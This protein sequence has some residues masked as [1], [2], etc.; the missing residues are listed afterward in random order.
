MSKAVLLFSGQAA[1]KVGMGKDLIEAY[2]S[3]KALFEKAD[4]VLNRSLTDV[5][6]NGPA[7]DLTRTSNCQPALLLHGL[8]LLEIL[9]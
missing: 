8:A 1:Q 2:P 5:M 6:F 4:S 7:E 9:R 3:A